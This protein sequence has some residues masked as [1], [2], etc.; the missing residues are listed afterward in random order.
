MPDNVDSNNTSFSDPALHK[1]LGLLKD[2]PDVKSSYSITEDMMVYISTKI[3]C[4]N[5]RF[6]IVR[7]HSFFKAEVPNPKQ[8]AKSLYE[9][10]VKD[11]CNGDLEIRK[12]EAGWIK[13]SENSTFKWVS[14]KWVQTK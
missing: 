3:F 10:M 14:N 13:V 7:N 8:K 9:R 2:N 4:N 5:P 6:E 1:S 12:T 11:F